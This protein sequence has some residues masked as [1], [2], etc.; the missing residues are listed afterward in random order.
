M[1]L[2]VLTV[3]SVSGANVIGAF[4]TEKAAKTGAAEYVEK[5]EDVTYKKKLMKNDEEKRLMYVENSKEDNKRSLYMNVVAFEL[6]NVGVK[7]KKK[8]PNMPKKGM[9]AFMFFSNENRNKIKEANPE[10]SFGEIG[11][12][13]GEAWKAL[14]DKQR[15]VYVKKS[16]EDKKRYES[17]M[18]TYTETQTVV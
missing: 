2:F 9:S 17:D 12:K 5:Q 11:R 1:S 16:V 18:Q 14:S 4:M 6:P 3:E 13:V 8:D 10:M 15:Q 7:T